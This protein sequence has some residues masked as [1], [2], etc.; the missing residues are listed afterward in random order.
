MII[1]F[2]LDNTIVCYDD[3]IGRM[4]NLLLGIEISCGDPKSKVKAY[5]AGRND[6]EGWR[7]FQGELYGLQMDYAKPALQIVNVMR[8]LTARGHKMA[9]IS[10]RSRFPHAGPKYNL[11]DSAS[12]W[13]GKN[14]MGHKDLEYALGNR[15]VLCDTK[16][17]KVATIGSMGCGVFIDDLVEILN[18]KEFPVG[19]RKI[20]Y[21]PIGLENTGIVTIRGMSELLSYV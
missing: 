20:L 17:S 13:I 9:I 14:L 19:T 7:K 10:H 18:D 1:G 21:S 12:R 2:D 4:A 8:D 15:I 6:V 16:E 5:F 11:H 3:V